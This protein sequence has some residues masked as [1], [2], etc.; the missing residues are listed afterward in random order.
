MVNTHLEIS[1]HIHHHQMGDKL[2]AYDLS[3]MFILKLRLSTLMTITTWCD[4][5]LGNMILSYWCTPMDRYLTTHK[6]IYHTNTSWVS[7]QSKIDNYLPYT[8]SLDPTRYIIYNLCVDQVKSTLCTSILI[9]LISFLLLLIMMMSWR[10]VW[11]L[12]Q[13]SSSIHRFT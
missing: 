13:S 4:P 7:S 5:P 2:Q 9:K 10:L 3:K 1:S 12:T 6:H 8:R 11:M